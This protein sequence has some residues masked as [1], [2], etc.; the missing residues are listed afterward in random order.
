MKQLRL[1]PFTVN[2]HLI[3]CQVICLQF[4]KFVTNSSFQVAR[5]QAPAKAPSWKLI[6]ILVFILAVKYI[7]DFMVYLLVAIKKSLALLSYV[8]DLF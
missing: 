7:F 2:H 3:W 8:I 1:S 5:L 6:K 4:S